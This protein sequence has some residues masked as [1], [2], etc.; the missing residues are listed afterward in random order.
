MSCTGLTGVN[1]GAVTIRETFHANLGPILHPR[2]APALASG[3]GALRLRGQPI[4]QS[5]PKPT[6][7]QRK[8]FP[9]GRS[10]KRHLA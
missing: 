6:G 2:K 5:Q 3:A 4:Q 9:I 10:K 7:R 8:V 1:T